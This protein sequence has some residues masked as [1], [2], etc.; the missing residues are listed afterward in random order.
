MP[1]D[2]TEKWLL[3]AAG[4]QVMKAARQCLE[5]GDVTRATRQG[6]TFTGVV[7]EGR[8]R[9]ACG[10]KITPPNSADNLCHCPD[11][12]RDGRLCQH[13]VAVAIAALGGA[14]NNTQNEGKPSRRKPENLPH[15]AFG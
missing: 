15:L 4:W 8:R 6:D 11:A 10:L 12:R 7:H 2:V 3:E 9:L 14:G 5:R 1:T 13:S